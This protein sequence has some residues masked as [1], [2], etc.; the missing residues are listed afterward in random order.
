MVLATVVVTVGH[1]LS[2]PGTP[3]AAEVVAGLAV[4]RG[5]V[6]LEKAVWDAKVLVVR[7]EWGEWCRE[8]SYLAREAG[9]ALLGLESQLRIYFKSSEV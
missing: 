1:P 3:S 9:R 5:T 2:P 4:V 7:V 6:V 8:Y